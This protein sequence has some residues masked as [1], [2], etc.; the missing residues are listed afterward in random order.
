MFK[1]PTWMI[2]IIEQF[3]CPKCKKHM[4]VQNV[5]SIGIRKSYRNENKEALYV[6]YR[7]SSCSEKTNIE[8]QDMTLGE[9]AITILNELEEHEVLGKD[10]SI[11]NSMKDPEDGVYKESDL[12]PPEN[13]NTSTAAETTPKGNSRLSWI[14]GLSI[15]LVITSG[16]F[17]Y[18]VQDYFRH[19]HLPS[20][21]QM[22][23]SRNG[24][25]TVSKI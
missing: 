25:K 14:I 2:E 15:A 13:N 9:F 18:L 21:S 7:C 10:D 8:M 3:M 5:S 12:A 16:A 24:I 22:N 23:A 19:P 4:I 20:K 17:I 1:I 11:S 6:E